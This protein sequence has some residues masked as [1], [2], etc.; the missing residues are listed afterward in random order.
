MEDIQE[1]TREELISKINDLTRLNKELLET[2]QNAERLKFGWTGSLGQWFWDYR[3]N[4]VIFNSLK[5]EAI[6]Y[7]K[8]DL[9]DKVPFQFFTDKLHPDDKES[10]MQKMTDHL[11]GKAPVWEAKYRIQAKDGSW[12]V[13]QDRGKVTEWS[14]KGEPLFLK[15]IVFDITEEEQGREKLE[16]KNKRMEDRLRR[17][18]LTSLYSR[19]AITVELAR[20][21]NTHKKQGKPL[22]LILMSIDHYNEDEKDYGIVYSEEVLNRIGKI[23]RSKKQANLTAGRYREAVFLLLLEDTEKAEAM[24]I[25]EQLRQ[26]VY[27]TLFDISRHVSISAGVSS[28]NPSET[29]SELIQ[30]VSEKLAIASKKGGNQVIS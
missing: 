2:Y 7:A 8:E 19:S 1:Y 4:E 15:G 26:E 22:S 9:P 6:G 30:D 18:P 21:V 23:I 14:E 17:D 10:V 3:N 12:K 28:Y 16:M 11:T 5:A 20:C 27:H 25:A 24:N 29:I 13:Y